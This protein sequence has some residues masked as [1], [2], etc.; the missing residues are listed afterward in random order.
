M[1]AHN[2]GHDVY[3][4]PCWVVYPSQEFNTM[5]SNFSSIPFSIFY[6]FFLD[7]FAPLAMTTTGHEVAGGRFRV[8]LRLVRVLPRLRQ[9]DFPRAICVYLRLLHVELFS[10]RCNAMLDEWVVHEFWVSFNE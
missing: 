1:P 10:E 7:C 8:N 5:S 6:I 3:A 2:I 9:Q 4:T